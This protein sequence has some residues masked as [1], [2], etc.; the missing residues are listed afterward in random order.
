MTSLARDLAVDN[1]GRMIVRTAGSIATLLIA[2]GGLSAQAL[3]QYYPPGQAYPPQ[4]SP[5]AQTYSRQPLPPT[6]DAHDLPP[7]NVP[8]QESPPPVNAGYGQGTGSYPANGAST[9]AAGGRG[10]QPVQPQYYGNAGARPYYSTPG[11][12]A[13]GP[14]GSAQQDA[15]REEAMR[16]RLRGPAQ[17]V[18]SGSVDPR[19][20]ESSQGAG[21]STSM[22]AFPPEVRPETDP[23]KELPPQFRRTLVD[24]RT[25]EPAGTI[26]VDTPNTHLYLV[27]GGGK[28]LRYG[29][30]VGR[31][32]FTWSGAQQITRMLEWPDWTPPEEMIARQPY[33]PRFMA[34]G[35]TNPLGA[36]ALYLGNTVYR[37]HGTNQPSTIGTF[38]SS[39]CIR[40]TNE[41]VMDLYRRVRVG[42]LVVV[43]PG[44]PPPT[45]R[46][47]VAASVA[48]VPDMPLG[49][50][51]VQP[52]PPGSI[53]STVAR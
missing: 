4:G 36:R 25:N 7:L 41:D 40:L 15:I 33:L 32:G 28:A 10:S 6:V 8:V 3:A 39:G 42:T 14:P 9:P 31:D 30:G 19:V 34:G 38:V 18:G 21:P 26:I 12:I 2:L 17:I 51:P 50:E 53:P 37:I 27:L 5:P 49:N 16:S 52:R 43:L 24:Y 46:P 35:E 13:P 29:V 23:K 45:V 47:P 20:L 44:A 1:G 22:A 11:A 48:P